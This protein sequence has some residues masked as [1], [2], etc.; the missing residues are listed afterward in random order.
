MVAQ[1]SFIDEMV[2]ESFIGDTV[3]G[4]TIDWSDGRWINLTLALQDS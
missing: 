3:G 2:G 1:T 4:I